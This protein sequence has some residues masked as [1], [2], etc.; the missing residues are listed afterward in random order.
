MAELI[1]LLTDAGFSPLNI[2]LAIA[3]VVLWR[4]G[5]SR[6]AKQT[7]DR[8]KWHAETR[9]QMGKLEDHTKKCDEDRAMLKGQVEVLS[10]ACT[11]PDCPKR[12]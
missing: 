9:E 7:T 12:I 11:R 5:I 6:D 3:V 1:K 10:K 2:V 4:L 8:E